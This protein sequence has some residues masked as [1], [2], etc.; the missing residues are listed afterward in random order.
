MNHTTKNKLY[1]Q[2]SWDHQIP[3]SDL[4]KVLKGSLSSAGHLNREMLL[5]RLL[6]GYSWFTLLQMIP[7]GE[8]S[9][10]LCSELINKIEI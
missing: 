10:F 6:G 8:M 4:E 9:L 1:N 2:I 3:P 5:I 7:P